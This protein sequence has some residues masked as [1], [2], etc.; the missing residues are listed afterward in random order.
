[1]FDPLVYLLAAVMFMVLFCGT[2]P[3]ILALKLGDRTRL[4]R[5]LD[6]YTEI[7]SAAAAAIIGA[8]R[9]FRRKESPE[10]KPTDE[11]PKSLSPSETKQLESPSASNQR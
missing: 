1:M 11:A 7:A 8:L 10:L 9:I 4:E 6:L 5:L 3:L 2:I